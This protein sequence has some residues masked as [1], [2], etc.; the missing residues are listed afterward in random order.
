MLFLGF[1]LASDFYLLDA[2]QVVEVLPCIV[3][4]KL[5]G[6]PRGVAGLLSYRGASIPLFDLPAIALGRACQWR[7]STRIV[8]VRYSG[9]DSAITRCFA[10]LLENVT[11]LVRKEPEEF[12]F[13]GID[14]PDNPWLGYVASDPIQGMMQW[15]E[16][17]MLLTPGHEKLF[18]A[19]RDG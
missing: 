12:V 6:A 15:I 11:E 4:K 13:A 3:P 10:L 19:G 16:P 5:P 14:V 2:R 18:S 9:A 8:V 7:L 1:R 17:A